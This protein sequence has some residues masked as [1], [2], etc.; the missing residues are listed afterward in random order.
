[1]LGILQDTTVWPMLWLLGDANLHETVVG[2]KLMA[3]AAE[4]LEPGFIRHLLIDRGYIGG[5]W[6]TEL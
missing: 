3:A 4:V 6:L 5:P 1:V 2:K